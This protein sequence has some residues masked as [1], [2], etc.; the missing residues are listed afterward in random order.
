MGVALGG[1]EIF[2]KNIYPSI[3]VHMFINAMSVSMLMF[4]KPLEEIMPMM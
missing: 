1:V 3:I 4:M 2:S